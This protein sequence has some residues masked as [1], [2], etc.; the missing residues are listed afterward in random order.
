MSVGTGSFEVEGAEEIIRKLKALGD[1][2]Q[3]VIRPATQEGAEIVKAEIERRALE[4]S[5][6]TKAEGFMTKPG[7]MT[8]Q[9]ANTVVTIT[10]REFEHVFYNEFGAP[11]RAKGGSLPARP[12]IRPSFEAKKAEAARIVEEALKRALGL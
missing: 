4:D 10:D 12:T 2:A 9:A 8:D 5:G 7:S 6:E 3:E 1:K 11:N